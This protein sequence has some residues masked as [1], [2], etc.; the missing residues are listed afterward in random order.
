MLL[1]FH[2]IKTIGQAISWMDVP[3]ENL[4]TTAAPP[5]RKP[6]WGSG[7]GIR[8]IYCSPHLDLFIVTI[9]NLFNWHFSLLDVFSISFTPQTNLLQTIYIEFTTQA[10]TCS[11]ERASSL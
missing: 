1:F 2:N 4:L 10:D 3:Q 5:G 7:Q 9:Y 11:F 6:G 8:D